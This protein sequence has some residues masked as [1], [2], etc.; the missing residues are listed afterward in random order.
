MVV[1]WSLSVSKC[2]KVSLQVQ[3]PYQSS[4]VSSHGY[5]LRKFCSQLRAT[6]SGDGCSQRLYA[7]RD[8][9]IETGAGG[10]EGSF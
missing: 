3:H 6:L 5:R 8:P 1:V 2:S 10:R 4:P 7:G 9:V